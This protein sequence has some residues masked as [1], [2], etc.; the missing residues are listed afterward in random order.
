MKK[1]ILSSIIASAL[2]MT[3]A[4]ADVAATV[5]SKS[6]VDSGLQAVYNNVDGKIT[7]VKTVIGTEATQTENATGLIGDVR[8]L[9]DDVEGLQTAVGSATT[10]GSILYRIK[11]LEENGFSASD[12]TGTAGVNVSNGVVSINGLDT[13][14]GS[15]NKIYV[16]QNNEATELNVQTTWTNPNWLQ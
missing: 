10:A 14:T 16:L 7:G 6:Y 11:D 9:E 4:F 3:S 13:S 2:G 15:D 8:A 12:I 5:A 1:I